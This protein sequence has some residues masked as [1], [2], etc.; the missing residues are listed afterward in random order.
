LPLHTKLSLIICYVLPI[1]SSWLKLVGLLRPFMTIFTTYRIKCYS[2]FFVQV[3]NLKWNKKWQSNYKG[4]NPPPKY[5]WKI[6]M[7]LHIVIIIVFLNSRSGYLLNFFIPIPLLSHSSFLS[8][9][10]VLTNL[11]IYSS[12]PLILLLN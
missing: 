2:Y 1:H 12:N 7:Y 10:L 9:P 6:C 8:T 5:T 4:F 3:K 11:L